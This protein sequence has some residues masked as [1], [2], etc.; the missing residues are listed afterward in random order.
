VSGAS[1]DELEDGL[2]LAMLDLSRRGAGPEFDLV[3][4][5]S[6][7]GFGA[8]V[9][10]LVSFTSDNDGLRGTRTTTHSSVRFTLNAEGK[11]H[12]LQLE[13]SRRPRTFKD[14]LLSFTRSDWI[15]LGA[16]I[17]SVFALFKD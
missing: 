5:N 8:S 7:R 15:A 17:V 14:R 10:Q 1:P 11:R 9:E 2:F 4:I 3:T 13:E 12:A 6:E 16:F